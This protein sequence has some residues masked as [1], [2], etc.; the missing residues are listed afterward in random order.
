MGVERIKAILDLLNQG[1]NLFNLVLLKRFNIS[2]K[3]A[4][5]ILKNFILPLHLI[6][7]SIMI[8]LQKHIKLKQLFI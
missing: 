8:T 3:I 1:Y 2:K 6:K 4:K 5:L 7:Q